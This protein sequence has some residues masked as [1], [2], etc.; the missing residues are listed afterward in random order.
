M[1]SPTAVY[2][3]VLAGNDGTNKEKAVAARIHAECLLKIAGDVSQQGSLLCAYRRRWKD[4]VSL[5]WHCLY[6]ISD[7][8]SLKA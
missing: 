7:Q 3:D 8:H 5:W 6:D 2:I 4:T 1:C